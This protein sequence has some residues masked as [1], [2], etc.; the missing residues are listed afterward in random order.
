[1]A[2]TRCAGFVF[3]LVRFHFEVES[4]LA[5][6]SLAIRVQKVK[7]GLLHTISASS[8]HHVAGMVAGGFSLHERLIFQSVSKNISL[9]LE[10]G[11]S[12]TK[13]GIQ[14]LSPDSD[15]ANHNSR[16]RTMTS[17][18]EFQQIW[19]TKNWV[20]WDSVATTRW[21]GCVQSYT[22]SGIRY[23]SPTVE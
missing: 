16:S 6:V 17:V 14:S 8:M 9:Q 21:T 2:T 11:G 20:V 3:K 13:C 23:S 22:R 1:M 10:G 5:E 12:R 7:R 18:T 15:T 4:W 19:K